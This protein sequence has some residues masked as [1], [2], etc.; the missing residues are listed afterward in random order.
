MTKDIYSP[1]CKQ[2]DEEGDHSLAT[3]V[4]EG[5]HGRQPACTK[6]Y[7]EAGEAG[8]TMW[9]VDDV[10]A[11]ERQAAAYTLDGRLR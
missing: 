10:S 3:E 6:H 2:C 5:P 4:V 11:S 9:S 8:A 1:L 7:N